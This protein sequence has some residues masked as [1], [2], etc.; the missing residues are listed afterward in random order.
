[1]CNNYNTQNNN[2]LNN[3]HFHK[4]IVKFTAQS[5]FWL[6][7]QPKYKLHDIIRDRRNNI[8]YF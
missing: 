2:L 4:I 1:M 7:F 6:Q 3:K 8:M 5:Y